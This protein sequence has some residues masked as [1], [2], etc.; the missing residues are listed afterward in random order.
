[1]PLQPV[2]I[3][4]PIQG[5]YKPHK[6]FNPLLAFGRATTFNN[7]RIR[8]DAIHLLE[9]LKDISDQTLD[10][11]TNNKMVADY[12]SST[13]DDIIYV[14]GKS[15]RYINR[16]G[17]EVEV[18]SAITAA[19]TQLR[20]PWVRFRTRFLIGTSTDSLHWYDPENRTSRK[21]GLI[22]P[23]AKLTSA[24]GAAGVLT[25][26]YLYKYTNVND[27][28][29]ESD[30]SAVSSA[31]ASVTSKKIDLSDILAGPTG[32]S[33]RKVYRT[34]AGGALYLLLTT[35]A[36]NSTTTYTDNIADTALGIQVEEDQTAP[37][38]NIQHVWAD[39][40]R[41]YLL[42]GSDGV[43]VWAS[44]I[45]PVT[46]LPNWEAYPSGL[47]L[48]I[49][50]LGGRDDA[51][52][53]VFWDGDNYIFGRLS[54]HR[55]T[56]D[57]A[58][59]I[60]VHRLPFNMGIFSTYAH[61]ATNN[62]IV[63]IN[64]EK[65]LIIFDGEEI[66]NLGKNVQAILD[67]ISTAAGLSGPDMTFDPLS[68]C[69]YIN[70]GTASGGNT[71]GLI[72]NLN[73]QTV[74]RHD[75]DVNISYWSESEAQFYGTKESDSTIVDWSTDFRFR[76]AQYSS[77]QIEWFMWSPQP[78]KEVYFGRVVLTIKAQAISSSVP[79]TLKVEY[80]FDG[81]DLFQARFVDLSQEFLVRG[82]GATVIIKEVPVPIYKKA[83]FLTLRISTV[84]TTA[85]IDSGMEI[86]RVQAFI[87][88]LTESV[89]GRKIQGEDKVLTP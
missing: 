42:D 56:G 22:A 61:V 84:D 20:L 27:Q 73:N 78:G 15:L 36:D 4:P 88:G 45:D 76:T 8:Q 69:V 38:S 28:G 46:A 82:V 50:L 30:P 55:I 79:P 71:L 29:H 14:N 53:G 74:T 3:W 26:V 85:S 89:A 32:T 7:W 33:S 83:R 1:M 6:T 81:G 51:Q 31:L 34:T 25:G 66:Q 10:N 37:V 77:Q 67:T 68:N 65:Q 11:A 40:S 9:G 57:V 16:G 64:N 47:A 72:L 21:A 17:S 52:A 18:D 35:I 12:V 23:T 2:D 58:T 60:T 70:M 59:G 49:P 39:S 63:F 48:D 87:E 86:Y 5:L 24:E 62:G 19:D 80:A 13:R 43:T 75:W 54:F 41:V 44:K